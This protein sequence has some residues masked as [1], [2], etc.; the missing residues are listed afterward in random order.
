M[1]A[2]RESLNQSQA[3]FAPLLAIT[4][5]CLAR[6]EYK[7]FRVKPELAVAALAI[8][9]AV[10]K[11]SVGLPEPSRGRD[12][13]HSVHFKEVPPFKE[14]PECRCD[15]RNCV[16]VPVAD[17]NWPAVGHLWKF[18][19]SS[20]RKIVY[21]NGRAESVKPPRKNAIAEIPKVRC[22]N[23][24][25]WRVLSRKNVKA[26]SCDVIRQT[27]RKLLDRCPPPAC[28]LA[29]SL[30][31]G[32]RVPNEILAGLKSR[33]TR[34]FSRSYQMGKRYAALGR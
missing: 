18:A 6:I 7:N 30:L 32:E 19:G 33:S 16:L 10:R 4:K 26:L 5:S 17:G 29:K 1:R 8:G 9:R 34:A 11:G 31:P 23:C 24:G 27:C 15:E 2:F 22:T 14:R 13:H 3:Q 21:L 25:Q 28:L 12:W 20:C